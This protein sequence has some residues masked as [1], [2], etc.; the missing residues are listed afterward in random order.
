MIGTYPVAAICGT[1]K[2]FNPMLTVADELTRQGFIVL[3]PFTRKCRNSA[4]MNRRI[5]LL[6]R[7]DGTRYTTVGDHLNAT[8]IADEDLD[9]MHRTKIG[10][11]DRVVCVTDFARRLVPRDEAARSESRFYLGESTRSEIEFACREGKP[12][13]FVRLERS[14]YRDIIVWLPFDSVMLGAQR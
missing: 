9:A 2:L 12:V 8:A 10:V 14:E 1:M 4:S 11:A 3:A 13:D 6:A 7:R 5:E